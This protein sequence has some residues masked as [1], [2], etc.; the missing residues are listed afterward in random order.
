MKP[1]AL[2]LAVTLGV[3]SHA[4]AQVVSGTITVPASLYATGIDKWAADGTFD[5]YINPDTAWFDRVV[6]AFDVRGGLAF[7]LSGIPADATV[8]AASLTLGIN[9]V[10]GDPRLL[11]AHGYGGDGSVGLAEFTREG[12]IGSAVVTSNTQVVLPATAFV[13]DAIAGGNPFLEVIVREE[14]GHE[15]NWGMTSLSGAWLVVEY[16]TQPTQVVDLDIKPGS[17]PN[18]INRV[19]GGMIPVAVLSSAEFDVATLDFG[20]LTF[21]RTGAEASLAFCGPVL[22]DVNADGLPDAVCHFRTADSCFLLT[23]TAGVLKGFTMDGM[24]VR[25]TDSV[26]IVR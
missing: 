21:G 16:T 10:E 13:A 15:T 17:V 5:E 12:L 23:D 4:G 8:T 25:G 2:V 1:I 22:E 19:A 7:A 9:W 20:S 18:S 6:G 14:P 11:V 26:R 3:A 24:R